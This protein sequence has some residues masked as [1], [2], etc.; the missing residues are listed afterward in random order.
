[1]NQTN[2]TLNK[3]EDTIA[4]TGTELR[5]R[6]QSVANSAHDAASAAIDNVS[7]AASDVDA[8]VRP[9]AERLAARGSEIAQDAWDATREAGQ[10]VRKTTKNAVHR[11]ENYV[12]DQPLRSVTIAFVAGAAIT[13]LILASRSRSSNNY[14]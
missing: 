9:A 3:V 13:A 14:R 11:C 10:K 7:R 6:A 1:M 4:N 5:N 12:S 8:S 2:S